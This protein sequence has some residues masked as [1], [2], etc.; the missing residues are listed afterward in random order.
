ME[1][2]IY[3]S[4][5]DTINL[6]K[7]YLK[8]K[9]KSGVETAISPFCDFVVWADCIGNEK[10][11]LIIKKRLFSIDLIKNFTKE[12]LG[13]IINSN[14]KFISSKID[15]KKKYN[16]I[17]SY[18]SK[19][20]FGKDGFF[21]DRYFNYKSNRKKNTYWFLISLDNYVPKKMK[22][23]SIVYRKKG[24]LNLI[25][26]VKFVLK[27]LFKKNF[28][29]N[30]NITVFNSA[31]FANYFYQAFNNCKF[32]LYMPY[33]NRP[34]Q[35]A[36]IEVTKRIS[37]S[38]KIFGYYHRMPEPFQSEMIYKIKDIDK[39]YVC[40]AP[41]KKVFTKYFSW[42]SK[43]LEIIDSIRYSKLTKRKKFIFLPFEIKDVK[44]LF[45]DLK[46]LLILKHVD[47]KG[48][49]ISIHPLKKNNKNHIS[50]KS[51]IKNQILVNSKNK[52]KK[53][54]APIIMGE[55]GSVASE[56]LDTTGKVYHISNSHLDIF[57]QEI[58]PN[59]K[60]KKLSNSIY[61]YIKI[62]KVKLLNTNGKKNNF[63]KLLKKHQ[64]IN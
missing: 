42:P 33:E 11:K 17:Y 50:L 48:F 22:N 16:I 36:V 58:W 61:E 34:H 54:D 2:E 25:N 26:F 5:I 35:N 49:K 43:K 52:A 23:I 63:E 18:C 6:A 32:N 7:K 45:K 14:Y 38:N 59:I 4:Q 9:K 51:L 21:Y 28:L 27:N 44:S 30:T 29:D 31:I 40:S 46:K 13:I 47:I 39:L 1:K 37:K 12:F 10:I 41:Q 62:G 64:S 15:K 56:M 24:A 60:V 8:L 19:E 3:K 53:L 57:S 20:N 55:P